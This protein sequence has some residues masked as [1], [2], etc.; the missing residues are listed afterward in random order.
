MAL[1][2]DELSLLRARFELVDL[3][4]QYSSDDLASSLTP[5]ETNV[6]RASARAENVMQI[7]S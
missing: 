3:S 1:W 2:H 6:I 7:Q 5:C 4:L